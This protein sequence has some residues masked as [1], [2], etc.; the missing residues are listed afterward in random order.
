MTD[1][2]AKTQ[3]KIR[4]RMSHIYR[5]PESEYRAALSSLF[6]KLA[7][8]SNFSESSL[9]TERHFESFFIELFPLV[10]VNQMG[11][12]SSSSSFRS[13]LKSN[14]NKFRPKPFLNLPAEY[15]RHL[16]TIL[17]A[18]RL[19]L[20]TLR[21]SARLIDATTTSSVSLPCLRGLIRVRLCYLC[22]GQNVSRPCAGPCLNVHRG[23]FA[24]LLPL[25][26][27][28]ADF[29]RRARELIDAINGDSDNLIFSL[30]RFESTILKA[31]QKAMFNVGKYGKQVR[32]EV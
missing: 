6:A 22:A 17:S 12:D 5:A 4:Y 19:L 23:C 1:L 31:S 32:D 8:T 29:M 28:W 3:E 11:G 27:N 25:R 26:R 16:H 15:G 13:C 9:E 20:Q 14:Y 21:F 18:Y 10:F 30:N 24:H 2:L 7:L